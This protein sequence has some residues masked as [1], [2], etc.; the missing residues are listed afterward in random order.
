MVVLFHHRGQCQDFSTFEPFPR[1][2][3]NLGLLLV[4]VHPIFSLK[5]SGRN[6]H[7]RDRFVNG[8][9]S[10]CSFAE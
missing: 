8:T 5:M 3:Q 1:K 9:I 2:R 4:V 6:L 10:F 7:D